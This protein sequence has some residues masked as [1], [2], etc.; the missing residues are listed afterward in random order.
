MSLAA[1][2]LLA[3][4]GVTLTA[5]LLFGLHAQHWGWSAGAGGLI[6][7]IATGWQARAMFWRT[8]RSSLANPDGSTA[9]AVA[10]AAGLKMVRSEVGKW[11]LTIAMFA[12]VFSTYEGV[13]ALPLLLTFGAAQFCYVLVPVAGR[14]RRR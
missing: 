12:I 3:L 10:E 8:E 11:L 6:G 2:V 14:R 13:E 7:L 1:S 4:L 5:A 9:E